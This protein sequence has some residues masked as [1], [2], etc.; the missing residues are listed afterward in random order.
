MADKDSLLSFNYNHTLFSLPKSSRSAL[1]S[2]FFPLRPRVVMYLLP[3]YA[4]LVG[5]DGH[6][7]FAGDSEAATLDL[8]NIGSVCVGSNDFFDFGRRDL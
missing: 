1:S 6:I 2:S 3:I 5:F 4:F 7:L 8:L